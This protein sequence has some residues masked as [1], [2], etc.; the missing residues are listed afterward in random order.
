VIHN[1]I[2]YGQALLQSQTAIGF[3]ISLTDIRR[4]AQEHQL[5][6]QQERNSILR[7]CFY[8]S[9]VAEKNSNPIKSLKENI[10]FH[11]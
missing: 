9:F 11:I 6:Q 1:C 10:E 3:L 5:P 8:S 2:Q 7:A 4:K